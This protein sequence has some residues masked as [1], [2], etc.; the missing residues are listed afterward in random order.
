MSE[1]VYTEVH[2]VRYSA[3]RLAAI[4]IAIGLWVA[5]L[6]C[7]VLD[8]TPDPEWFWG[9]LLGGLTFGLISRDL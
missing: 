8:D 5:G 4:V 7:G 2:T 6:L 9:L 1:P 3:V